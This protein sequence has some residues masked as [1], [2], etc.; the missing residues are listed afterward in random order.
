[1]GTMVLLLTVCYLIKSP[2]YFNNTSLLRYVIFYIHKAPK[3]VYF[4]TNR[5]SI[6]FSWCSFV[7]SFIYYKRNICIT[8]FYYCISIVFTFTKE[9]IHILLVIKQSY[10]IDF[11]IITRTL[12]CFNSIYLYRTNI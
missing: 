10:S 3:I 11:T 9:R 12:T 7:C 8:I 2:F 5:Y 1:M 4:F 6:S